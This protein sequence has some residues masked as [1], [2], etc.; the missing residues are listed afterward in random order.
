MKRNSGQSAAV[1]D[2][3]ASTWSQT[4]RSL[5]SAPIS[6]TGSRAFDDVVPTVAQTKQGAGGVGRGAAP[7]AALVPP[8]AGG[9]LARRQQRA[10][11]G[12]RSGVL[13]DAAARA[14]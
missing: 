4:P 11:R 14:A 10:E 8:E 9:A 12:A 2:M 6:A 5:Q 7:P 3:A 1:P 13:D